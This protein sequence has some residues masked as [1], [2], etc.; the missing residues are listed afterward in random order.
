MANAR[1]EMI[2]RNEEGNRFTLS[3]QEPKVDLTPQEVQEAMDLIVSNN[4]FAS[5]GGDLVSVIGARMV[6]R[7]VVELF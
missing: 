4:V 7:D 2:F 3:V 1:L 5:N 6:T